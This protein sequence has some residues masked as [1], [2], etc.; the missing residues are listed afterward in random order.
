M[1]ATE[2]FPKFAFVKYRRAAD[3]ALAFENASQI[4]TTFGSNTGFRISFSD[5]SRRKD[6]VA[7]HYELERN[8]LYVPTLFLGFPPITS[9]RI[10]MEHMLNI[11]EKYGPIV[12]Y[13][14][15]KSTNNQMR[16]Y[17]LFTYDNLVNAKRAKQ[18][19]CR[20]KDLLGEKRVEITLLLDEES[21]I[22]GRDFNYTMENF[23]IE[24]GEKIRRPN[25][26]RPSYNQPQQPYMGYPPA[27]M[28]GGYNHMPPPPYG[29][30]PPNYTY[31]PNYPNPNMGYYPPYQ[32]PPPNPK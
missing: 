17:F 25:R 12:S 29:Y 15:K 7:N 26:D 24:Q 20:R 5:P 14:L 28:M 21:V 32:A 2:I 4:Y 6:I 13:Y 31:P 18:E 10:E 16:S 9:A 8:S 1:E 22:T 27:P 19:L 23:A 30:A 3:A 11:C